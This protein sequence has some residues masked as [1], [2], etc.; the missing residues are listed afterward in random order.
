[1]TMKGRIKFYSPE[2]GFGFIAVPASD[3]V[4][5]HY[6]AL[7]FSLEEVQVKLQVTFDIAQDERSGRTCAVNINKA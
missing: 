4:F 7:N 6:S 3:D 2:R 5:F 1:M